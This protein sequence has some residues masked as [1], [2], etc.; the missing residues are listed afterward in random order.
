MEANQRRIGRQH[1]IHYSVGNGKILC[2]VKKWQCSD[3]NM[4]RVE[5]KFCLNKKAKLD[6][7]KCVEAEP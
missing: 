3:E 5:C 4:D 7:V 2:G 6:D 1:Q